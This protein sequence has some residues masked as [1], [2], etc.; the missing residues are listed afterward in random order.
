MI[1]FKLYLT[2]VFLLGFSVV[3][4]QEKT[5]GTLQNQ[6]GSYFGYTLFSSQGGKT[7]YL[8]DNEGRVVH[9]WQNQYELGQT[10]YLL[11]DGTLYRAGQLTGADIHFIG[12]GGGGIIERL[13]WNS[14]VIWSYKYS[15][16]MVRHHHDFEVLPNGNVLILAWELKSFEEAIQAGRDPEKLAFDRL[17]PDHIVEVEPEEGNKGSIVWEWHVFDHLIQ[18]FDETKDNYGV[19]GDHPELIDMNYIR[20]PVPDWNHANSIDYNEDLDQIVLSVRAFDELWIIDHSTTSMEASSHSGGNS[21]K[22]GDLIC[23]WGNP[24]TYRAGDLEDQ[25]FF[26]Q[27]D[28]HWIPE[29]LPNGG[30]IMIFNNGIQRFNDVEHST[31]EILQLTLVDGNYVIENGVFQPGN[32][33]FNYAARDK[34]NFFAGLFSGSQQLANG[35]LLICSGPSGTLFEVDENQEIVWKYINPITSDGVLRQGDPVTDNGRVVNRPIFRATRYDFEY[36]A[37]H[38]KTLAPG[39][40]IELE[41]FDV[42]SLKNEQSKFHISIKSLERKIVID[43]S[44]QLPKEEIRVYNTTGQQLIARKPVASLVEISTQ[45]F[46]EGIY[47]LKV[48]LDTRKFFIRF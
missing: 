33:L 41:A 5:V 29:N 36:P 21:G 16:E 4:A 42:L 37:F 1:R 47:I 34:V 39:E 35:N 19:V 15:D 12:G 27:H 13:D 24:R 25:I 8:I 46:A 28:V 43:F 40:T 23:R 14:N 10:Q 7:S 11:E 44:D 31:V 17:W 26:G 22:G 48:G 38:E 3:R 32:V 45:N 18:D 2:L 6:A 20:S 30:T 9:Q